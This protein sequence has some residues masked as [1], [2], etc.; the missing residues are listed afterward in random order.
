MNL[1]N[2]LT[3]DCVCQLQATSKEPAILELVDLVAKTG[4]IQNIKELK[5]CLFY[6]ERLMS[7]GIGLGIGI[8][9]VRLEGV[10]EP[11]VA[12]GVQRQGISDYESIDGQEVKIVILIVVEKTR[13][14]DHIQLLSL[15][16]ESLREET[17][18]KALLS[19]SSLEEI[20]ELIVK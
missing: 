2:I 8:P 17:T 5:E 1:K 11:V 3:E 4:R 6:R 9:H 18:R 14:K 12:L 19:A 7:T 13:H 10:G 16:M 15:F 20:Y